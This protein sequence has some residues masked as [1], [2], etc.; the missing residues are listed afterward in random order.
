MESGSITGS[1]GLQCLLDFLPVGN[2][3]KEAVGS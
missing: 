2:F 1:V 3:Q